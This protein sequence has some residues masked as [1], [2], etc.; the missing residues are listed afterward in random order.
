[1]DD[2]RGKRYT[3]VELVVDTQPVTTASVLAGVRIAYGETELRAKVKAAGGLWDPEARLWRLNKHKIRSLGLSK[4]IVK[5]RG[6][7]DA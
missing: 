5:D 2:I 6:I 1:M 4:R 7:D 3:T